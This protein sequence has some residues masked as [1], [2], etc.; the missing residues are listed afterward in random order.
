MLN[1][2]HIQ[3]VVMSAGPPA[4][5]VLGRWLSCYGIDWRYGST[6]YGIDTARN[7][8]FNR[9]LEF[10]VPNGKT[11]L[12]C[13]DHDMIPLIDSRGVLI[14]PGD[15]VYCGYCG[16]HGSKGHYGDNDLG[17]GCFRVSADLLS[18]MARPFCKTTVI[19]DVRV[20]CECAHFLRQAGGKSMMAGT[21]GH[22]QTCILI[23]AP[24]ATKGWALAWPEDLGQ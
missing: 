5:R 24:K 19:D 14:V 10:D 2:D 20:E 7:H 11:H 22:E 21:I 16:R 9:F 15:L 17:M 1:F 4:T 12:L 6:E 3:A 8:N 23:P 13:V 18:K